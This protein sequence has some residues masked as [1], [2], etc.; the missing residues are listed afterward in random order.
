MLLLSHKAA[1]LEIGWNERVLTE[2]DLY[3]LCGR[4]DI[5]VDEQPLATAGFYYRLMGRD[6]IAVNSRMD[7]EHKLFVL[8]HEFAHFLLHAPESGP[9]A[10]FHGIG[11]RSRAEVEADAFALCAMIP[12]PMLLEPAGALYDSLKPEM[13][14]S[15]LE[16][17]RVYNI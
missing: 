10:N 12:R 5:T 6:G 14:N 11:R 2:S 8:F 1:S 13:V 7:P 4:F 16:L 9:A 17:L 3:G 15:R